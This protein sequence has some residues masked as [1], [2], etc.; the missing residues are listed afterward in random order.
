MNDLGAG[1]VWDYTLLDTVAP[2][3]SVMNPVSGATLS[4]L[5]QVAVTFSEPVAGVEAGDLLINGQPASQVTGEGAGPYTFGF[6]APAPGAVEVSWLANHGIRDLAVSPNAFGGGSWSYTLHPGEFSGNVV[7]NEF[8]AANVSTNGLRDEDGDLEDWI[9]LY[10]RGGTAVNLGGWSL[11]DD[12]EQVDL[13]V[14]PAVTLGPGQYLVVFASGKDRSPANGGNLHANFKLSTSGQYLGLFN[15]NFPREVATQFLPAYPEQRPD[16]AYGLYNGTF[17]YL[18]NPSPRLANSGPASFS[19]LAA[20]PRA[21]VASGLFRRPFSLTL[22]TSTAGATIRYTLD[23]SEPTPTM[24]MLYTGPIS[25]A[26]SSA[27][28]MVNVRAVAFRSDLLCSRVVTHSYLFPD[29]VLVQPANPA[30]FPV[31]WITQTNGGGSATVVPGDYQMDPRV[32]TNWAYAGLAAQA[33]TNLPTLSV[34]ANPDDLFSQ[35]RGIY[36]NPN[37]VLAERSFWERTASAELILPD[38]SPG[39]HLNAGLRMHGG[40]SRDPNWTRKHSFRLFFRPAYGGDL[41]YALFPDSAV[42]KYDTLVV[43]AGFNMSW[44]NRYEAGGAR[45]QFVRDQSCSDLQLAMDRAASHGRFVHLYL[46]GLYWGVYNLRERPDDNFAATYLGG[47]K[48]QYDVVRN[49]QGFFDVVA[50]DTNAWNA[51]MALVNTGLSGNGQYEQLRQYLD[52]DSFIDYMIVNQYAGN[53]DWANHNWYAF[54]KR[55]TG[56]GFQFVSW[57]A[58]ITLKG[59][60][61][62]D[63]VTGYNQAGTP[64]MIHSYLRNNAEYRLKFADHVQQH[65]GPGGPLYVDSS[66]PAVD[67]AHPERNRPGALYLKRIGE[68]DP[69][70]V[71]E[72]ARWGDSVPARTNNPFTRADFLTELAW[73]TNTYFPQR[74]TNVLNQYVSQ[75]LYPGAL[76]VG[77]PSFNQAGGNVPRGF[78]LTMSAP[79]GTI[80]YTT[81]GADPRVYGTSATNSGASRYTGTALTLNSTVLVRARAVNNG[82]VESGYGGDLYGSPA[83]VAA[84]DYGA[85][86]SAEWW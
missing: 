19:G 15:A 52:V 64:T 54:R 22:S 42:Q 63:N 50:G 12:P 14:L 67:P 46:N 77:A 34:V 80:Y 56:A 16:L 41:D 68:V 26:G 82:Y 58:E 74:S 37:P 55:T 45:A 27:K 23:G 53:T 47:D 11:T 9:E 6:E 5:T 40:T 57:D 65:F 61:E 76:G 30:G 24:G 70:I 86:V 33:L 18:T 49:T 31:S 25:V 10:N 43:S 79:R 81:N 62:N 35:G 83:A 60:T 17:G 2:A 21:S 66:S 3:V 7:I 39:F 32:I 28:A 20:D 36:A 13:W 75:L 69:A 72:S 51:M 48:L 78:S 59:L 29:Y 44:N 4:H 71:L 8:L 1:T 84:A 38:G 73:M 85:H